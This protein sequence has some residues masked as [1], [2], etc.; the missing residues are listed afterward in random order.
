MVHDVIQFVRGK[1]LCSV[2]G[3]AA[4]RPRHA[5]EGRPCSAIVRVGALQANEAV[6]TT[7]WAFT[8]RPGSVGV[9]RASDP[10]DAWVDFVLNRAGLSS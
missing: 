5:G 6:T 7:A 4:E 3:S 9:A 2:G 8:F 10:K 1:R